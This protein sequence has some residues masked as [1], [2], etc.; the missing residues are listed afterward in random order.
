MDDN[1]DP[2]FIEQIFS[3]YFNDSPKVIATIEEA[4]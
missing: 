4:L 1:D 3:L 2:N